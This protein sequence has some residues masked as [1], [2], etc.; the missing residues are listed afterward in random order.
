MGGVVGGALGAATFG[1]PGAIGGYFAGNA[2]GG[3]GSNGPPTPGTP[4]PLPTFNPTGQNA[5]QNYDPSQGIAQYQNQVNQNYS[6]IQMDPRGLNQYQNEALR[7]GPSR[8]AQLQGNQIDAQAL[9]QRQ[10]GAQDAAGANATARNQLAM[11]GG[12][13][14]GA[15]ERIAQSGA[16]AQM[17]AGQSAQA[18]AN[19]LKMGVA[20][21][22]EQ[23]RIGQLSALPGLQAQQLAPQLQKANAL[24]SAGQFGTALQAQ[25]NRF[26]VEQA[27]QDQEQQNAFNQ[28]NYNTQAG[29]YGGVNQGA[30]NN[31][32]AMHTGGLGGHGGILGLG[33]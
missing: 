27:L 25:G 3:N 8:S 9:Q 1:I 7:T 6:G 24:S 26:G 21:Q 30:Q 11:S 2:I 31:W 18:Q 10:Q 29:I 23:N 28:L 32:L 12:L 16:R 13:N 22:D 14:S 4:P 17:G 19:Q 15:R 5:L 20:S 33:F